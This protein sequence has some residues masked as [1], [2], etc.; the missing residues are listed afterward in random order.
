MFARSEGYGEQRR[1]E[2]DRGQDA[3][4]ILPRGQAVDDAEADEGRAGANHEIAAEL[5]ISLSIVKGHVA[6]LRT[7]LEALNRAEVAV[8]VW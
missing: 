2:R 8:W 3:A 1:R 4:G 7:K 5:F 6:G